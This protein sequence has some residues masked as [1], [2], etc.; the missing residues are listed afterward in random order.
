VDTNSI[1]LSHTLPQ[2]SDIRYDQYGIGFKKSVYDYF[3]NPKKGYGI[4]F[5]AGVGTKQII[6]NSTIK[7]L[8]L[9][10][11]N[12]KSYSIYDS[13]KL[14]YIQY[15][16]SFNADWFIPIASRAT[17]R[18]QLNGAHIEAQ[19]IFFNELYRI[20]GIRTLKG[21]DEQS[22]FASSYLIINTEL[23]YLLQQ[24]SNFMLF[25]NGAWYRN[26][27]RI[28]VLTDKP[29]GFGAGL[30]FETGAGIFSIYYAVGSQ[31]NSQIEFNQAKIHFG[32]VNYF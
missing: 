14:E 11:N 10:D 13:M 8:A 20:G 18:T 16:F 30:N 3:L 27:A 12:G 31:F 32:F 4:E 29:F 25:W 23:R 7:S 5:S 17:F 15:K 22:I 26:V 6:Q 19:N 2:N 1:K 28:P 21:F 9:I 24:N